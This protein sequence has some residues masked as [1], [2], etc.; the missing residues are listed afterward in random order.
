MVKCVQFILLFIFFFLSFFFPSY[1]PAFPCFPGKCGIKAGFLIPSLCLSPSHF[2][3]SKGVKQRQAPLLLN[4]NRK[5][6]KNMIVWVSIKYLYCCRYMKEKKCIL[7]LSLPLSLSLPCILRKM[8][9]YCYILYREMPYKIIC[10]GL[11]NFC[12][13]SWI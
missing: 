8:L 6:S 13:K 4:Y 2:G 11:E 5:I 7:P 9:L 1:F 12:I 3:F 10:F